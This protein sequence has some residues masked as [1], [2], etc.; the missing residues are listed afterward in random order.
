MPGTVGNATCEEDVNESVCESGND[1]T[2]GIVVD[3]TDVPLL[4]VIV[5]LAGSIFTFGVSPSLTPVRF[6]DRCF[7]Q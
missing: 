3:G 4:V 2:V 5:G 7:E 6:V 1:T